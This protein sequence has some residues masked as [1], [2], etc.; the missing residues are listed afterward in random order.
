[1]E[2]IDEFN[3]EKINPTQQRFQLNLY[4]DDLNERK[5]NDSPEMYM[6]IIR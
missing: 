3:W 1:M 4:S 6:K 5:K 2:G